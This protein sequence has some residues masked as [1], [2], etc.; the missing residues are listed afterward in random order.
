MCKNAVVKEP[1]GMK[2]CKM[3]CLEIASEAVFELESL[4]FS[5][6]HSS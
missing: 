2:I 3:R 6:T 1:G 5:L 4:S